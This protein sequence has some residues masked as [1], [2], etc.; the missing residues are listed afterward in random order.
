MQREMGKSISELSP[1]G[2][3]WHS[4]LVQGL[5]NDLKDQQG[6]RNTGRLCAGHVS[7][8]IRLVSQVRSATLFINKDFI[9][10][11][12]QQ[13]NQYSKHTFY[14]LK[15][16]LLFFIQLAEII[17]ILII[18]CDHIGCYGYLQLCDKSSQNLVYLM[19]LQVGQESGWVSLRASPVDGSSECSH[20][21]ARQ[22]LRWFHHVPGIW[23]WL[24]LRS[25][26]ETLDRG[27]YTWPFHVALAYH[28]LAVG[29]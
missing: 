2:E 29:F 12:L 9:I 25:L 8:H 18:F 10:A 14:F 27:T 17:F 15:F 23:G 4:S 1:P 28:S 21:K 5:G 26:A 6:L 11:Q 20:P 7:I 19:P 16:P 13:A 22:C 3:C 24:P